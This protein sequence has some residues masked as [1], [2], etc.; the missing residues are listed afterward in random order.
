MS[1]NAASN[2]NNTD[3]LLVSYMNLFF[4][5]GLRAFRFGPLPEEVCSI[6]LRQ[7]LSGLN[8]LHN[9]GSTIIIILPAIF[10]TFFLLLTQSM[11]KATS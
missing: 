6:Y 11:T 10:V 4:F 5:H 9:H 8:F 7:I 3:L 2:N 1:A